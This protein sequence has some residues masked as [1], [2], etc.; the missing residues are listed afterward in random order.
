MIF[1]SLDKYRHTGLLILRAGIGAMFMMHGFPKLMGGPDAW[2]KIG[3]STAFL[4]IHFAP[5]FW[6]FMAAIAEFGGGL[7]LALGFFFRPAL[8]LL[9]TVMV[10]A[11]AMHFGLK[12]GF[13]TASH[14]IED[15]ILFLSLI[16]IGPGR[17]SLDAYF[18]KSKS[19]DPATIYD[20]HHAVKERAASG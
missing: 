16:L 14:A 10:T 1:N 8:A 5:M 7:L 9:L 11:V 12:Q 15:G 18:S 20:Y 4:G 6:G 17:F 13:V 3:A 2:V 19:D